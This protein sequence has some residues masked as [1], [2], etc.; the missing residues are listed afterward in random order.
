MTFS[1]GNSSF[2]FDFNFPLKDI[3]TYLLGVGIIFI[4]T[5]TIYLGI[6]QLVKRLELKSK[7][8]FARKIRTGLK[9][10]VILL[11]AIISLWLP[12]L[13]TQ[14]PE[15][16]AN[17]AKKV[18]TLLLIAILTWIL[19]KLVGLI[20]Y[21]VLKHYD[22]GQKNNLRARKIY[23]QFRIIERIL[24]S[25][26]LVIAVALAL[27]S[28]SEIRKI[29]LSLMASAG[30]T[31]IILGFAA[32]KI[33]GG[34]LAGIQLAFTQP[35]RLDD[36][37][38]VENEW[39]RIEEI[40]LTYVVVK[41]WDERRLVVPS[42]YFIEKPFQNWTRTNSDILGTIFI[43]TDYNV[44]FDALREEQ[45]RILNETDL[46]DGK[47]NVL[48]VTDS[49]E[50]TV[51]IRALVS[52]AD[53]PTAWDLRVLVREKLITFLQKNYPNSLPRSRVVFE[54]SHNANPQQNSAQ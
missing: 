32:Q 16:I 54:N 11:M 49:T 53:S 44:P 51:E 20:K 31:G 26:I 13:F 4:V 23:T 46:W 10:P 36:V 47:V 37:V 17:P 29:G 5:F 48:Q 12:M 15:V 18:L 6:N 24:V 35:I 14:V 19:I 52:A 2:V 25:L 27:M 21:I 33:L 8:E 41:I 39:G 45:T 34:I 38:I 43:Y 42:S 30:V 50:K 7:N 40:N 9:T 28:F 3:L 1:L 22:I